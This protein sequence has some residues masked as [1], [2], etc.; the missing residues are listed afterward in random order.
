MM[1]HL[2]QKIKWAEPPQYSIYVYRGQTAGC[3]MIPLGMVVGHRLWTQLLTE[4]GDSSPPLFDPTLLW[5]NGRPTQLLLS[6]CQ[7]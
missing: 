7:Y 4:S 1:T 3:T 2:P 5:P 6:T